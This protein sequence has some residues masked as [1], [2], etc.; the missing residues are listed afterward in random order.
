MNTSRSTAVDRERRPHR[1]RAAAALVAAVIAVVAAIA[2]TGCGSTTSATGPNGAS[3]T[4]GAS[5]APDDA[6]ATT[7]TTYPLTITNCGRTLQLPQAPQ[8]IVS[9]WPSIT[10]MLIAL[11]AGD[12]IAGQAFTDQSPPLPQY[13]TA[14]DRVKVLAT[15]AVSREQL[16]AARPD[17]IVAD[18][19]YHFNGKELPTI[20]A[21]NKLGI[22]VYIISS[23]CNGA[24]TTGHV[25]D[26]D[27]DLTALGTILDT[28]GQ[29]T[30]LKSQLASQLATAAASTQGKPAVPLVLCQIFDK[31]IYAEAEGLYSDV[32]DKAGG[33]D[34]Y[35][36]Q[37]P[38]GQYYAQ[39]SVED[40]AKKN[41]GTIVY[42]YNT[43]ADRASTLAYLE[44]TFPTV[45]AVR[46]HRLIALPSVDFIDMRAVDGVVALAQALHG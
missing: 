13:Q 11:G 17:L 24:V 18:G 2:L 9:L 31:A 29:A 12:R 5:G 23:F 44:K 26:V 6:V 8:R 4:P 16:L 28:T 36:G 22:P 46:D 10:E 30:V 38:K 45:D 14:F 20:A 34:L 32:V 35:D 41:P 3:P 37:L 25:T 27:T 21:L 15:D 42:L 1:R 19:E 43:D 7:S 40:I 33:K 39:V